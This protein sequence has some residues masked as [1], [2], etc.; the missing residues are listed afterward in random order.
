MQPVKDLLEEKLTSLL[1]E[2]PDLPY[3]HLF[4]AARYSLLSEAKR[5]R[6]LL[7]IL[8]AKA[9]GVEPKSALEFACAIECV[10][11]YSLIHDDLPCMDDDDFRRGKPSLHKVYPESHALLTGDY[12]LTFAFEL[13]AT[14]EGATDAQKVAFIRTLAQRIGAHGMVGGQVTDLRTTKEAVSWDTLKLMHRHKTAALIT[15]SLEGGAILGGAPKAD[16]EILETI[17]GQIG[18]GFQLIDDLLDAQTDKPGVSALS[19]LS[20]KTC[21]QEA[22]TCLK[23]AQEGLDKL[24]CNVEDL[25]DLF[26]QLIYRSV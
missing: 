6:P 11:T 9:Y 1:K 2:R 7:L 19:F 4:T 17:G 5:L 21:E 25:K 14:S 24:S 13:I 23:I 22:L 15:A 3:G 26:N 8:T 10:H 12:L 20:E 16:L 18:L